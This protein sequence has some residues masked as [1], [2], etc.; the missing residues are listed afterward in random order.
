M[1]DCHALQ[2]QCSLDG[3]QKA[4]LS[5]RLEVGIMVIALWIHAE[6]KPVPHELPSVARLG[7]L[8]G[9]SHAIPFS[10]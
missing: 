3:E 8:G 6:A 2:Q 5:P 10:S 7:S 4:N 9:C 1:P